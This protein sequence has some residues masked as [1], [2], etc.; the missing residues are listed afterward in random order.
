MDV[1]I[2][3]FF[4]LDSANISQQVSVNANASEQV[5]KSRRLQREPPRCKRWRQFSMIVN[6]RLLSCQQAVDTVFGL[7]MN[8][9]AGRR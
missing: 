5:I 1:F 7:N 3:Y 6:H 8:V 2:F 4:A 9:G